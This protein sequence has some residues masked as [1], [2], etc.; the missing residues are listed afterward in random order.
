MHS[1]VHHRS[2]GSPSDDNNVRLIVA[3][4]SRPAKPDVTSLESHAGLD[5]LVGLLAR[6]V[7]VELLMA[8]DDAQAL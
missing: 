3:P 1:R 8:G 4:S 5:A 2:V 6:L 7:G